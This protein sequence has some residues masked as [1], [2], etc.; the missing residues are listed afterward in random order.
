MYPQITIFH[1]LFRQLIGNIPHC[2]GYCSLHGCPSFRFA[3]FHRYSTTWRRTVPPSFVRNGFG[4]SGVVQCSLSRRKALLSA[5]GVRLLYHMAAH[6]AAF[7]RP[8]RLRPF[9]GGSMFSQPSESSAFRL[10]REVIIPCQ[11]VASNTCR[12]KQEA[13]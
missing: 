4:R 3:V 10:R 11:R 12:I 5:Y 6:C 1:P 13:I 8:E 2:C 7:L 9:R